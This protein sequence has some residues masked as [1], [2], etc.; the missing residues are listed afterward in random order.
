[1]PKSLIDEYRE[2]LLLGS[3]CEAG[4]LFE[5]VVQAQ[6]TWAELKR[7][8]SWYDY[9]EIQPLS[10]NAYMLRPDKNGKTIA[11]DLE[12]LRDFNRTVVELARELGKPVVATGDVHFL[13]PEDEIYRHVLLATKGFEDADAP[14]PLYFRTTDEMLE[15]FSYLGAETAREVVIDNPQLV[16]AWCGDLNPLPNGLFA[17]KLEDSEGELKRLVW[18]KAK[19]LY[20][21][22]PP[23]IVV[24]RIN[25][26]LGDIL[27][28]HYDVIY[29]SAQKLVQDS[30]DHGY[31]V[32]SRG[33]VG[34]S[35]VAFHVGHHRGQRP[36]APLPLPQLQAFRLR[37]SQGR[38]LGLWS[39]YARRGV[40]RVR[41]LPT[42]KT[43]ST[44]PSRPSWASA[45][46]R[47]PI[48]T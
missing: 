42:K 4:E 11:R 5:A 12:E 14:N 47:C 46:T 6:A 2:G 38:R 23:Q 16:A 3:A 19:R 25:A 37:S 44:S 39:R 32:G 22:E 36:A 21:E 24:D 20:G 41:R 43:A 30:L 33:S 13:D 45:A 7:I 40:P 27:M 28:R 15:E 34:S 8:A 9:L 1:M 26:E 17:P 18:G 10:N 29:M 31:L 48:S 35:I